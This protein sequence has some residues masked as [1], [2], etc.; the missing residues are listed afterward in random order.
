MKSV[1]TACLL[2]A[3][4]AGVNL[5]FG[6]RGF[7]PLDQSIVFDGGWRLMSG[8]VP[9]RD[10]V[11]PSGLV[12]SAIQA[13]FFEAFG[14]TWFAYCLHASVV[15]GLFAAAIYG[16]LRLCGSTRVE[17]A[18][19]GALSSLFF[20][21]PTGTPFMDQHSF[22]FMTLMFLAAAAGTVTSGPLELAAWFAV[23]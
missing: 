7:L 1:A 8:Q 4:G 13:G 14:V 12:P 20:Y 16:L 15:N 23:P 9:F 3:I 17:A 22:F 19:F 2:F 10:F 18:A 11:A 6:R 21:P 5:T